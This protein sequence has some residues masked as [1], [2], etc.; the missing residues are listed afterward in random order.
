MLRT[1]VVDNG[2]LR[3]GSCGR[4]GTFSKNPCSDDTKSGQ[5]PV[6]CRDIQPWR[7]QHKAHGKHHRQRG[8]RTEEGPTGEG[9][10]GVCG[11]IDAPFHGFGSD[12]SWWKVVLAN[13]RA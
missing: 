9:C 12:C 3:F 10:H 2:C 7:L 13:Y 8:H 4:S 11:A 1:S 6:H 5:G